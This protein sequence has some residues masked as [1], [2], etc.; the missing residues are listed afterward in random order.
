[1]D[2]RGL[3][4]IGND[5]YRCTSIHMLFVFFKQVLMN[6]DIADAKN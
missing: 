3:T 1:M 5:L 6:F 2:G 4:F